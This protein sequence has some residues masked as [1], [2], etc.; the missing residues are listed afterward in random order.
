MET[1]WFLKILL[2]FVCLISSAFFSGSEVAL[3]S[4]DKKKFASWKESE[5]LVGNYIINL[6]EFPRR[7]L[8]TILL[9]NTI[10]NVGASIIAV[11]IALDLSH[12]LDLSRDLLLIIQILVLTILILIF[13][14]VTPKLWAAKYP[15]KFAKIVSIP[16]YWTSVLFYPVAKILTDIIKSFVSRIKF[17]RSKTAILS[18]EIPDLADLGIEKGTLEEEEHELIHG[19]VAFRNIT[20][21]VVMTPRVDIKSASVDTNFNDLMELITSTG[22]SRIPVFEDN[23]DNILG[24]LYA[25]DLLPFL[26]NPDSRKNLSLEENRKKSYFCSRIKTY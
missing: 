19:L 5:N 2:L 18:S 14:E 21:R 23:L 20:A 26:A 16:L 13:G 4:I 25:K 12:V 22:H 6:L 1:D 9:G 8:V 15:L 3:F 24:I 7:L 10:F 17:D 11:S